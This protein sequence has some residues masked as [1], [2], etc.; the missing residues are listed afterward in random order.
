[1]NKWCAPT[2]WTTIP[3]SINSQKVMEMAELGENGTATRKYETHERD[4]CEYGCTITF[5]GVGLA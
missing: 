1:M 5:K 3:R 4:L 2:V